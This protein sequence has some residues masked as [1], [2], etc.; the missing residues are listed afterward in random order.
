MGQ[1][2]QMELEKN[3]AIHWFKDLRDVILKN[4]ENLERNQEF[5]KFQKNKPGKF[6]KQKTSRLNSKN[7]NQGGGEMAIM[8][9]GRLFEKVGVNISTVSGELSN[10]AI[11]MMTESKN[12]PH[13]KENPSFWASGISL[14]AHM[15]NPHLPAVHMNTRMFWTKGAWWFGGGADLNPCIE[16]PLDTK[17]FHAIQK[18]YCDKHDLRFYPKYK[19]WADK[20]FY[21][22]HRKRNR[23]VGG[24]FFDEHNTGNWEN[25]FAF[26]QDVGRAFL[27]AFTHIIEKKC[28]LDWNE[29]DKAKQLSHRGLYV[30]YNLIY[31]RG[32]KFGLSTGHD[33]DAVLMS[34]PPMA[35]WS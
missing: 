24:I 10:E 32:T 12:L 18:K 13:L 27:P 16:D 19:D 8:S 28:H 11:Q 26:V 34:L 22:P 31:D 9:N 2:N 33:P 4:F 7:I 3:R 1:K 15:Q 14:V 21:V 35:S 23:G 29:N 17:H 6:D 25:D 30:E 20:Y 5:G